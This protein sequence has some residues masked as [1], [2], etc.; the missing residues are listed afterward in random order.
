MSTTRSLFA[1]AIVSIGSGVRAAESPGDLAIH[2][3]SI[4]KTHCAECHDGKAGSRSQLQILD[5]A[6]LASPVRK[7]PPFVKAGAPLAS[8]VVEFIDDGSMPP[9]NRPKV[10]ADDAAVVKAWIESGAAAYPRQFDDGFAHAMILADLEAARETERKNFRYFSLHHL[11]DSN[12]VIVELSKQRDAFRKAVN[13]VAKRELDS[14]K[15]IDPTGTIFRVDLR[16]LGWGAT[17]FRRIGLGSNGEDKNL[18]A[19]DTIFDFLLLEYPFG[20]MPTATKAAAALAE[21]WLRP[22]A[23]IRPVVYVRADWFATAVD[24]T[25]LKADLGRL[26]GL[27]ANARGF[28]APEKKAPELRPEDLPPIAIRLPAKAIPIVPIDAGYAADYEPKPPAPQIKIA[29]SDKNG[30]PATKFKPGDRLKMDIRSSQDAFIELIR[31]DPEG[32][33]FVE[34]LG[35]SSRVQANV[36]KTIN[37]DGQ[38]EGLLLGDLL[39]K[40][41]FIVYAGKEKFPAGELLQSK[42][43]DLPIERFVHPFYKLPRT[44]GDPL[45]FDPAKMARKTAIFDVAK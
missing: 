32:S 7:L 18:P 9:G 31:I 26:I 29:I 4:L 16:E 22:I 15:A 39:G 24:G 21:L 1:L 35:T 3:R 5:Y 27:G 14:L 6:Q 17:P 13:S 28:E 19:T 36:P 42:H 2:A 43:E 37:F 10:S 34:N 41:R 20:E 44:I 12:P 8:Q 25:P 40:Q 30:K 38:K 11:L 33:I 45:P 23:Q